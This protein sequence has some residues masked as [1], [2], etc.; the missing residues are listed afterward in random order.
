MASNLVVVTLSIFLSGWGLYQARRKPRV[1]AVSVPIDKLPDTLDGF[2]I[3]HFSDVHA[4][5]TIKR[6]QVQAIV[7]QIK[8]LDAD[9]IA[10]TGDLADRSVSQLYCDIAPLTQLKARQGCFIVTGNHEYYAGAEAWL[11]AVK[12]MGFEVLLNQ[13]RMLEHGEGHI[14]LAGVTAYNAG[15]FLPHH[16]SDPQAAVA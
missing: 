11:E 14:L 6:P 9:L 13:H 3:V 5:P 12:R 15:E 8:K 10:C 16:T 2:R 4:G 7:D 1:T